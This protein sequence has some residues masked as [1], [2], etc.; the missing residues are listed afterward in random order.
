M[1]AM[2]IS[3]ALVFSALAAPVA[4]AGKDPIYT[5]W[6][7]NYAVGGYDITTFYAGVPLKGKAEHFADYKGAR[8]RFSTQTN[9]DKFA[10]APDDFLPAY[11]G[12]CAWALANDKLAKGNPKHWS[13]EDGRLFLNFNGRIKARWEKDKARFISDAD[14]RWPAILE[15]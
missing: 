6:R 10:A 4:M 9:R 5:G 12:Y 2:I 3:A 1:K 13:V 11:G 14:E 8:W 7:N 15:D